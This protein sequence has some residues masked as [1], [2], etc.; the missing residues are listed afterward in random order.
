MTVNWAQWS[1]ETDAVAL[2]G[3]KRDNLFLKGSVACQRTGHAFDVIVRNLSAGGLLADSEQLPLVGD[4]LIITLRTVG[5]VPGRVVWVR[6]GRFGMAFDVIIDPA[7]VRKPVRA[8]APRQPAAPPPPPRRGTY[9]L[10]LPR[11]PR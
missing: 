8:K 7:A 11:R 6:E 4:T 9:A 1:A 3:A 5:N 2:R 10:G